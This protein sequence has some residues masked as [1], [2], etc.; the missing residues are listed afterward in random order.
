MVGLSKYLGSGHT[1]TRVPVALRSDL[2]AT[3]GCTTS[4]PA[5]PRLCS[6]PSRHTVTSRRAASALVTLT[7]T[8]CR[9]PE[10]E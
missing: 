9:P 3:R 8:P 5:N 10:K 2:R 4:P 1:V 7:P 6:L